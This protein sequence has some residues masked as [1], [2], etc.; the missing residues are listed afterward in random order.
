M[1]RWASSEIPK[2]RAQVY[3]TNP[4]NSFIFRRNPSKFTHRFVALLIVVDPLSPPK[5][6][7]VYGYFDNSPERFFRFSLGNLG[8]FSANLLRWDG[9][10]A[11]IHKWRSAWRPDASNTAEY[12]YFCWGEG[13][14]TLTWMSQEVSRWLVNGLYNL[15]INEVYWGYNPVTHHLLTSWDIQEGSRY[16]LRKGIPPNNPI[17]GMGLGK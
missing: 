12:C 2:D 4:N 6:I 17:L 7:A 8:F 1:S 3:D 13:S 16:V 10:T 9:W 11:K 15:L 14:K 5:K